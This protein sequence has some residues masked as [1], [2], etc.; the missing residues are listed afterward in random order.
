[1]SKSQRLYLLDI[2]AYIERIETIIADGKATFFT[3]HMHQDAVIRN[4]EVIG[5]IIKRLDPSLTSKYPGIVWADYAGFRDVLIHQY[6]K[7]LTNIVWEST[8]NDLEPL[9]RAVY[10]LLATLPTDD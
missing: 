9:R 10:A 6:D 4:F 2:L 8:Q 7:V 3:S 5:E 1:M